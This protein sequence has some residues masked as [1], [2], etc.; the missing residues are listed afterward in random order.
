MSL[1]MLEPKDKEPLYIQLYGD[2]KNQIEQ[3]RLKE[4]E[5]LPSIRVLSKSL[6]I[7][8]TTVEKAYQQLMSEGYLTNNNRSRYV[9]N[10]YESLPFP[11]NDSG[12]KKIKNFLEEKKVILYDFAS[13]E[14]DKDGFDFL[15]WKKYISKVFLQSERL[16]G[17]GSIQGEE[18]LRREIARYVFNS[19]GVRTNPEQIVVGAGVQNLLNILCNL[20]RPEK[21]SIAFEEPGFKNGRRVFFDHGFKIIPIKM[22]DEGI[23]MEE[24]EGSKTQTVYVSP[25]HQF[26]TGYIMP[27]G[28]RNQLLKWAAQVDGFIIEDDY[29][30]E[31]RYF[32]RPIP[33]L[34][35]LDQE[36]RVIYLG[37]FSKIIPPSIRL[38]YMILP[39]NLLKRFIDNSSLYHQAASTLEQLALASF[40]QDGHLER[41]I[42][43]LRKIYY[44]KSKAFFQA[45]KTSFDDKIEVK[46]IESGLRSILEIKSSLSA[47]E[48]ANMA[49]DKGCRVAP[50]EDY[51]LGNRP[52]RLPKIIL[53][54]SK[55]P[56][57]EI[58]SG[59]R[60]LKEAW[61]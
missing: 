20:L 38:S 39:D 21:E 37:S 10:K 31:F 60:M 8:K 54:F 24:L 23:D 40:M 26:P 58:P 1:V 50:I 45:L 56:K 28:K 5:R 6:G 17:Y 36:E 16:V 51:Y 42:R 55:I 34:K 43:R 27:V 12:N 4:G 13:G 41:Q 44:E 14:M 33:A 19:R 57:E 7:S 25:S 46:E 35:A 22:R 15:L 47:K 49:L 59:V 3:N 52:E 30:S 18:E 11:N 48:L 2:F 32:G 9:V 29:D 61:F 53:Y